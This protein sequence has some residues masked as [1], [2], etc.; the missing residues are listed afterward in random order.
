MSKYRILGAAAIAVGLAGVLSLTSQA[1]GSPDVQAKLDRVTE[2]EEQLEVLQDAGATRADDPAYFFELGNVYADLSRRE[3]AVAAYEAALDL[4]PDYVEVL[5]NLGAIQS[6]KGETEEAIAL[7]EKAVKIRPDDPR[8]YVNLGSALYSKGQ[9]YEAMERYRK[10]VEVDPTTYEAHYQIAVAFADAGIYREAI[11]SWEKV[12]ELAPGTD[13]AK[14]AQEN[15][16]V[17]ETIL[18]RKS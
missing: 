16:E 10:A 15:I 8:A 1:Q 18:S 2:L 14:S 3:E 7:L 11:R 4:N 9:Y 13:A 12:I 6:D 5:V 17:V